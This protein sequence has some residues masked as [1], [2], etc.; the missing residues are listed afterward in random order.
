MSLF[1]RRKNPYYDPQKYHHTPK[2]FRNPPGS[3]RARILSAEMAREAAHFLGEMRRSVADPY[4]FTDTH[5]IPTAEALAAW[6][7]HREPYKLLWLGHACFMLSFGGI[8]VLTDPFLT[9]YASPVPIST[10]RRIVPAAIPIAELPPV[11]VILLSHN[12]YDHMDAPALR[13]LAKRF[14]LAQVI[15]P[16]GLR[17]MLLAAGFSR[18]QEG[19]WWDVFEVAGISVRIVPAVHTSRRGLGDTNRSLWCGFAFGDA[20][21]HVYFAGDTAYGE[22]FREI[23]ALCG[24]FSLG[25]VPIGAY[26]PRLLMQSVHCTP[27]EAIQIGVDI[28][29]R[30]L[31]GMHWGTIRLTLEPMREPAERFLAVDDAPDRTVLRIGETMMIPD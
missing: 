30:H 2:G 16:L 7:A 24:P 8:H 13:Q 4:P 20:S 6:V 26:E 19:D 31:V 23:G 5:V 12:H 10:T 17:E 11:H 18:V 3:P 29:A 28:R 25:L 22:V 27:E 21:R 15:V 14:P 9:D 1:S